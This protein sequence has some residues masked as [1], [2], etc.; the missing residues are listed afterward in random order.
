MNL[1]PA[2]SIYLNG[3][4]WHIPPWSISRI[5][6]IGITQTIV[7]ES[8]MEGHSMLRPSC[9]ILQK[10]LK[11]LLRLGTNSRT[12]ASRY[13]SK[14][15]AIEFPVTEQTKQMLFEIITV[16]S[17]DSDRGNP[18]RPTVWSLVVIVLLLLHSTIVTPKYL[19]FAC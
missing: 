1:L 4:E 14:L 2:S 7:R 15:S 18:Y 17:S 19:I 5:K 13:F 10:V 9:D 8:P 6:C 11:L 12:R 16:I 3:R